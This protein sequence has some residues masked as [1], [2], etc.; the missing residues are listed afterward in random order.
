MAMAAW[1]W[2]FRP[3]PLYIHMY[4]YYIINYLCPASYPSRAQQI[5]WVELGTTIQRPRWP[6]PTRH[7]GRAKQPCLKRGICRGMLRQSSG[8]SCSWKLSDG[9]SP[10]GCNM[11][12]HRF[13]AKLH[14]NHDLRVNDLW[15]WHLSE[16]FVP[17]QHWNM[18]HT[19]SGWWFQPLWTIWKLVGMIIPNIWK[20]IKFMFQT[21]NQVWNIWDKLWPAM[22]YDALREP[23][24]VISGPQL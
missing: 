2:N 16:L 18:F 23:A 6:T 1:S 10:P 8:T 5:A 17:G 21:T 3:I 19:V 14:R 7:H 22:T 9:N 20:V 13:D 15:G 11:R 4:I 24:G 12:S